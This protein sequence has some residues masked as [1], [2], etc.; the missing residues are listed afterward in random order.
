[1]KKALYIS[2]GVDLSSVDNIS[3]ISAKGDGLDGCDVSLAFFCSGKWCRFTDGKLAEL[4]SQDFDAV[5]LRSEGNSLA[6]IAAVTDL[7][8]LRLK[9]VKYAVSIIALDDK[10]PSF[11]LSVDTETNGVTLT[12]VFESKEYRLRGEV[13]SIVADK[14]DNTTVEASYFK[15]NTWLPYRPIEAKVSGGEKVKFRATCTVKKVGE[16]SSISSVKLVAKPEDGLVPSSTVNL[17]LKD[18][19]ENA[20]IYISSNNVGTMKV[21][22]STKNPEEWKELAQLTD[23]SFANANGKVKISLTMIGDETPEIYGIVIAR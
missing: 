10:S 19:V 14:S 5:T 22:C 17:Y 7:S 4:P 13:Q 18:P 15:N 2:G 8:G 21:Y 20:T 3:G 6:E 1:M 12:K 23:S 11:S 16:R 9:N